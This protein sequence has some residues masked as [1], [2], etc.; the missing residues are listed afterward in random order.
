MRGRKAGRYEVQVRKTDMQKK[1]SDEIG[2][3]SPF[4][5]PSYIL[6]I[7]YL[8]LIS[9]N[10]TSCLGMG[11]LL[12]WR[13]RDRIW[14]TVMAALA[15]GIC[16]LPLDVRLNRYVFILITWLWEKKTSVRNELLVL[17]VSCE[18]ALLRDEVNTIDVANGKRGGTTSLVEG[19]PTPNLDLRNIYIFS[20]QT[21]QVLITKKN[22]FLNI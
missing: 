8:W 19:S 9:G 15:F 1:Q 18:L 4:K 10:S 17:G 2:W 20:F 22:I 21:L 11:V 16:W 13:A 5:L 3:P 6:F 14:T 7:G 12:D